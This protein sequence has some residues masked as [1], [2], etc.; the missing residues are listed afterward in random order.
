MSSPSL[1]TAQERMESIKAGAIAAVAGGLTMASLMAI[2]QSLLP[3]AV[4]AGPSLAIA[5]FC[6]F[7]FGVTYRYIVRADVNPHLRSGAVGA[8]ALVRGLSQI[9]TLETPLAW[10]S[11]VLLGESFALF[12]IAQ[13]VLAGA[14]QRSML[15]PFGAAVPEAEASAQ[16]G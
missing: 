10:Q 9:E 2:E 3:Q 5:A 14:M 13:L 7:L 15:Q 1:L 6:T 4:S 8:F 12:A 16:R 11:A